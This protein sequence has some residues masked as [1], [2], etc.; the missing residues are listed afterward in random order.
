MPD[1]MVRT[2]SGLP[3]VFDA[4]VECPAG[5]P[6][7][8]A[9]AGSGCACRIEESAL[10]AATDPSTLTA[11]CLGRYI[12]CPTWQADKHRIWVGRKMRLIDQGRLR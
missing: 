10:M 3:R 1:T 7:G 9:L 5:E 4:V 12:E 6:I 2:K 11:F 8:E